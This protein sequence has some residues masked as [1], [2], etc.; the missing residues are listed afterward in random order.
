MLR[1]R[2]IVEV[3]GATHAT[4]SQLRKDSERDQYFVGQGFP[5]VRFWNDDVLNNIDGVMDGIVRELEAPTPTPPRNGGG[6]TKRL[7]TMNRMSRE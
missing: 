2:L 3:D 1:K 4:S 6:A 5:V 7:E